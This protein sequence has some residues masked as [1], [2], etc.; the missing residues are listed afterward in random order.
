MNEEKFICTNCDHIQEE[1]INKCN[2]CEC[3]TLESIIEEVEIIKTVIRIDKTKDRD[4]AVM[5]MIDKK[6]NEYEFNYRDI[7]N[8]Y[9]H[10]DII[11]TEKK[12][13]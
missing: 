10:L 6:G 1:K 3:E 9:R 13:N 5:L 2:N 8:D 11:C 7:E 4:R 12:Q